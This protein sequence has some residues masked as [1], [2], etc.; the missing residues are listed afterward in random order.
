M[1]LWGGVYTPV[2]RIAGLHL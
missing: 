1:W 2:E